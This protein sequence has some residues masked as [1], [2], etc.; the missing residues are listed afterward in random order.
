MKDEKQKKNT[1]KTTTKKVKVVGKAEYTNNATGEIEIMDV[2]SVE[3]RDFNFHKL[4]LGH[5]LN[6][7]D[8]IGNQ[9]V[10]LAFWI[11]DHLN[12]ENQLV[13]TMRQI[14]KET[15]IS[16]DTISTTFKALEQSNFLKRKH[17]GCYV[18]NPDFIFKGTR[19]NRMSVLI[20]YHEAER[21]DQIRTK[22]KAD[23]QAESTT[24]TA[25]TSATETPADTETQV[26]EKLS[27]EIEKLDK[28]T[29]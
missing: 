25:T 1:K 23:K 4:W 17:S 14:Q 5:I 16:L 10:K 28:M 29:A 13:Y 19:G 18:V 22:A 11:I 24:D 8:I 6:S 15:K 26:Y 27:E 9:K 7:I 2:I 21:E 3:E 12:K 20:Q